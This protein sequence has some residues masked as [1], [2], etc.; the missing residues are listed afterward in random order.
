[1]PLLWLGFS[2]LKAFEKYFNPQQYRLSSADLE[3][4]REKSSILRRLQCFDIAISILENKYLS[5]M[6]ALP[7]S[8]LNDTFMSSLR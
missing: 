1:M 6:T 4:V 3:T 5:S 8:M 2:R 7:S